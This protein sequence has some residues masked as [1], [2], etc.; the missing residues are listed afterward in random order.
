MRIVSTLFPQLPR[1]DMGFFRWAL[2]L[3]VVVVV[4]LTVLGVYPVALLAAALL[5]PLLMV[6]YLYDVDVYEDEPIRV[7]ALTMAWGAVGG[8]VTAVVASLI[9]PV[10]VT[11]VVAP[12]ADSLI[13]R[14]VVVPLVGG[15]LML[16]GPLVLLRYPKF[17]D[18]LD[19]A[20]FGAASAVTFVAAQTVT[21]ALDL[22]SAGVQPPGDQLPWLGRLLVL[23]LAQPLVAAGVIG[24]TAGAFWLRHRAPARDRG[25]L[26][27]FGNPPLATALAAASLVAAALGLSLLQQPLGL[28]WMT[29]LAAAALVWLRRV[30]HL[31]LLQ[32]AAEIDIAAPITCANCHRSTPY[33]SFCGH[34]G[35]ALRALP[36]ARHAASGTP[37]GEPQR[38]Q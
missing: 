25:A 23:G 1:A 10:D 22:F 19:G 7:I 6:L 17:N 24:A 2:T 8:A 27:A 30:I 4:A 37:G 29:V 35:V 11:L 14:G 38:S 21:T 9:A 34:C 32:E 33:H 36:K 5:V 3:G 28:L 26:G 16:A 13:V 18:V 15:A 20:T 12:R 31:G